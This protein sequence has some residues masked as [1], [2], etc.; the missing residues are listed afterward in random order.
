MAKPV[1]PEAVGP[2]MVT[3]AGA[4]SITKKLHSYLWLKIFLRCLLAPLTLL[5]YNFDYILYF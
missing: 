3:K 5:C 2:P 1:L 4:V